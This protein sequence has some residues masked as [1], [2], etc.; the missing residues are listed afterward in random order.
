MPKH[1]GISQ[2]AVTSNFPLW[3][4]KGVLAIRPRYSLLVTNDVLDL[5]YEFPIDWFLT[6]FV[7]AANIVGVGRR[8]QCGGDAWVAYGILHSEFLYCN[9]F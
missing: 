2:S 8:E 3:G 6:P 7:V 1:S 5:F 4:T 9:A